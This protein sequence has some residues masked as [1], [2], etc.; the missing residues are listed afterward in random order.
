MVEAAWK[1][2]GPILAAWGNNLPN[3]FPNYAPGTLGP[4]AAE[5]LMKR[6]AA[7]AL[8]MDDAP[9]SESELEVA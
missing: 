8:G 3:D 5:L 7:K 2:V 9:P 1:V 6:D 4:P